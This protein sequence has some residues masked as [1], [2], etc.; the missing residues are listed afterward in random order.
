MQT[1][2]LGNLAALAFSVCAFAGETT[3]LTVQ[4]QTL[5]EKPVDRASVIINFVEGRSIVKLGKKITTHWE[6]R[7]NQEG[8]ARIP[9]IPQGK[10][11]VQVNAKGFQTFGQTFD[12]D[13]DEKTLTIKLNPPQ[14]QYSAHE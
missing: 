10:V 7:T 13:D 11:R 12:V 9:S 4:V 6:L 2:F 3:K 1:F 8:V 14:Q 5:S